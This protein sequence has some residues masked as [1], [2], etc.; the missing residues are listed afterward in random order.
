MAEEKEEKEDPW[1]RTRG[2]NPE[3]ARAGG[4]GDPRWAKWE[5]AARGLTLAAL[6]LFVFDFSF[7]FSFSFL[8]IQT[9]DGY[10]SGFDSIRFDSTPFFGRFDSTR[11]EI[12]SLD[13]SKIG[14]RQKKS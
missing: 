14:K 7:L 3:R 10:E 1:R 13:Y 8:V 6:G 5:W 11:F 9:S 4:C 2:G 12:S